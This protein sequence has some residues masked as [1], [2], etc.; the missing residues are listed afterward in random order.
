MKFLASVALAALA[1]TEVPDE[2]LSDQERDQ[3]LSD[4]DP[5]AGWRE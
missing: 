4:R 3:G 1:A 2:F 5:F